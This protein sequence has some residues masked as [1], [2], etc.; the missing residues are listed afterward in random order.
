MLQ[1]KKFNTPCTRY[2]SR[3]FLI[4]NFRIRL[5]SHHKPNNLLKYKKKFYTSINY[6]VY[7]GLIRVAVL[8]TKIP[9]YN[10]KPYKSFFICMDSFNQQ[11]IVPKMEF[12]N[13]GQNIFNFSSYF[14]NLKPKYLN[15]QVSLEHL[16]YNVPI[17]HITNNFSKKIIFVRSSG[18]FAIKLKG[19][20]TQ[21]FFTLQLPSKAI[22]HFTSSVYCFI[23]KNSNFNL[24]KFI[25]GKWGYSNHLQKKK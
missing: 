18:V 15:S 17:S 5:K 23:G 24:H 1:K 16:P 8:V 2:A 10:Y 20:K 7:S 21:K 14:Q 19:K 6:S 12:M 4:D 9:F 25:E 3:I 22:Y 11:Y 13:P